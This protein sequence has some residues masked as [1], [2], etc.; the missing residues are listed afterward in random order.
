MNSFEIKANII[1]RNLYLGILLRLY[2]I[3]EMR[4]YDYLLIIL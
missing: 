2:L 3:F 4:N 1:V